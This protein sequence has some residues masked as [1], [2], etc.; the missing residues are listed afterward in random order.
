MTGEQPDEKMVEETERVLKHSLQMLENYFLKDH[1]FISSD[2]ISI[3]DLQAVCELSQFW[4]AGAD[5]CEGKPRLV[6]WVVNCQQELQPH[7]DEVHKM[8][9][10]ARDRGIFK[11]KL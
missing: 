6:Q 11:G 3:A 5:P 1:K 2:E 10:L 7:F 9:Y 8:I 4:L